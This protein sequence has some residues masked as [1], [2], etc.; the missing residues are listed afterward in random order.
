MGKGKHARSGLAS[1]S[2]PLTLAMVAVVVAVA[3]WFL[4][5]NHP[6]GPKQTPH[7]D[8]I[9][10]ATTTSTTIPAV[11]ALQ[12]QIERYIA[13]RS[14]EIGVGYE[15]VATGHVV[16]F[17]S[18]HPQVEASVV[19]VNIL[20]AILH[21]LGPTGQLSA[22]DSAIASR[23]IE[24]SDNDA[25]T[26]L[27]NSAGG[28]KGLTKFDEEIGLSKTTLS[29]CVVC[30]SFPWPGWGLSA[31]TPA[32]ELVLLRTLFFQTGLVSRSS[33]SFLNSLMLNVIPSER[34]GVSSGVPTTAMV[35]LKNGW[36]PLN[37][38]S[39]NWQ[40]NSVGWVRGDGRNY[41]LAMFSTG[42]PYEQYGIDTLNS[43]GSQVWN[44]LAATP[45][46]AAPYEER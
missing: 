18:Q 8:S 16:V 27:W 33:K 23:M 32:D 11:G 12:R 6:G 24:V 22:S 5:P 43:I 20:G 40:I 14:G 4:Q 28:T 1:P 38:S 34:W 46:T 26:Q 42:N 31:T 45:P 35:S 10:T 19:K 36:L 13:S 7:P 9:T 29:S 21:Q 2:K 41:L 17:G 15:D 39:T 3:F 44:G 30:P 37:S 25:A